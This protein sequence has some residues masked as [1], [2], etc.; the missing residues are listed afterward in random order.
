M[1]SRYAN[2]I[3]AVFLYQAHDQKAR[4]ATGSREGYF[5]AVA[6]DRSEKGAYTAAVKAQL[7]AG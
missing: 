4:G 6:L 3:K 1:R 7:A 5:G 2:R